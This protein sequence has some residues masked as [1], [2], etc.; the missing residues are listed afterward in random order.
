M[1]LYSGY[2]FIKD[3]MTV[4]YVRIVY[5]LRLNTIKAV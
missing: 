3:A 2:V 4:S 1:I 5:I